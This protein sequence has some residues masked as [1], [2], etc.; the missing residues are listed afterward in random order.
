[1]EGDETSWVWQEQEVDWGEEVLVRLRA[2][3]AT[4]TI[5]SDLVCCRLLCNCWLC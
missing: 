5:L 1:M 2:C 3:E 4:E